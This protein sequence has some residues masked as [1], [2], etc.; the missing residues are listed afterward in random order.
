MNWE[1]KNACPSGAGGS[2]GGGVPAGRV[3]P[4]RQVSTKEPYDG[5]PTNRGYEGLRG[6]VATSESKP[7]PPGTWTTILRNPK[8]EAQA[9]FNG[10]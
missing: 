9:R 2:D 3:T 10:L 6:S 8:K 1:G 4:A 7:G 5:C